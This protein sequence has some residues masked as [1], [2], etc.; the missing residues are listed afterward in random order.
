[1]KEQNPLLELAGVVKEYPARP[2]PLCVLNGVDFTLRAGESAAIVGPSGCGKS[3]LLNLMGTLDRP[4]TGA[5]HILGRDCAAME[6][7]DLAR[8]RNK[9]IGFVF[10]LHHL[11]PQCTVF[12][13]ILVPSLVRSRRHREEAGQRASALLARVG[14]EERRDHRP[15]E[16]SG[17]ECQRTAV[18]RALINDPALLLADEPTG[19]LNEAAADAL[20]GLLLELRDERNMAV[21][22]VTHARSIAR[23]FGTVYTLERGCLVREE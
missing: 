9:K 19:A 13:N 4:D 23:R 11:L 3:T 14:L 22:I 21:V 5:I 10:Q 7:T 2:V 15:G 20:A 18:A 1:M 6:A 12:E 8:L 17:G 16:V